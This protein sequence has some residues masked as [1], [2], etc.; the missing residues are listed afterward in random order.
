MAENLNY[1]PKFMLLILYFFLVSL[2]LVLI[3]I[4]GF[5][6]WFDI[7]LWIFSIYILR[8]KS[9]IFL[10][11]ILIITL[12][13]TLNFI[14]PQDKEIFWRP[15]EKFADYETKTY[16]K[17]VKSKMT[18]KHGDLY[19]LDDAINSNKEF[20]REEREIT[21]ITDRYGY[22]N[23][24]YSINESDLILVGDSFIMGLSNT[25]EYLPAN[26]L[27]KMSNLKVASI[28]FPGDPFTYEEILKKNINNL[29]TNSKIIVF[30]FEGNDFWENKNIP[31]PIDILIRKKYLHMEKNR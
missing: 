11:C 30:Y 13:F 2:L 12:A 20:I 3:Y 4:L 8:K 27:S 1:K 7:L 26:L 24:K 23:D 31:I 18:V 25:Q 21:F 15:H 6:I 28:A 16:E 5:P 29:R 14:S 10:T 9:Q 22:R 19:K 17:N